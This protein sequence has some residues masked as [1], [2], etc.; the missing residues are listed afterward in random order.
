MLDG[1]VVRCIPLDKSK[2]EFV[3]SKNNS[4]SMLMNGFTSEMITKIGNVMR[5]EFEKN[6]DNL[7]D[8]EMLLP[9]IMDESIKEGKIILD[10]PTD[11]IWVGMTYKE[12]A[13]YLKEFILKEIDK[14]VYPKDLWN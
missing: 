10:I 4:C 9:D 13:E 7:M 14:G 3:V 2:D 8:Y 5:E 6:K 1:D 11:S 12:D